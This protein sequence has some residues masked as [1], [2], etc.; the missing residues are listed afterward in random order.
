MQ[1]TPA[2]LGQTRFHL[3]K[4]LPGSCKTFSS[5]LIAHSDNRII[6]KQ[7][8]LNL[9]T[10]RVLTQKQIKAR[11]GKLNRMNE[12]VL[13]LHLAVNDCTAKTNRKDEHLSTTKKCELEIK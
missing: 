11:V 3:L 4:H 5:E 6:G 9:F 10:I 13:L 8:K 2:S 7:R 1:M 12:M